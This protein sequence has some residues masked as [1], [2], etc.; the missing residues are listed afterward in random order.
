MS[1][2]AK[3]RAA[4]AGVRHL[5]GA[6]GNGNNGKKGVKV[7]QCPVCAK[8]SSQSHCCDRPGTAISPDEMRRIKR[9]E[10]SRVSR[11]RYIGG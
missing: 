3:R 4:K 11:R 5:P 10:T 8:V 7:F 9:R 1:R 2:R 6:K